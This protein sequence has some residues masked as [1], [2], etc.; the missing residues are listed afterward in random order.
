MELLWCVTKLGTDNRGFSQQPAV[1]NSLVY[2]ED[3]G[4][5]ERTNGP[6][7]PSCCF[8]SINQLFD[9][10]APELSPCPPAPLLYQK[11]V[12]AHAF[13]NQTAAACPTNLLVKDIRVLP[14]LTILTNIYKLNYNYLI[15]FKILGHN[16]NHNPQKTF[17]TPPACCDHWGTGMNSEL[18]KH[19]ILTLLQYWYGYFIIFLFIQQISSPWR[20]TNVKEKPSTSP[21]M[22]SFW[23]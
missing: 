20:E 1:L 2:V 14:M 19:I 18:Y 15:L 8:S 5:G 17:V 6:K 9:A 21:S 23:T 16:I 3:N 22:G 10:S 12:T 11:A 4:T 13:S 7:I